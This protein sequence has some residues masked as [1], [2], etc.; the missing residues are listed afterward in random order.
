[1]AEQSTR[2]T[3]ETVMKVI[4][5]HLV[6]RGVSAERIV[7]GATWKADLGIDSLDILTLTQELEDTF[8]V[9]IGEEDAIDLRTVGD[10]VDFIVRTSGAGTAGEGTHGG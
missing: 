3:D 2:V 5:D 9:K 6:V 8:Q 4:V 1:M 7:R 10:A